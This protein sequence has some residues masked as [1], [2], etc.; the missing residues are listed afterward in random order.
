MDVYVVYTGNRFN[1]VL[2]FATYDDAFD[3]CKKATRWTDEEIE[4]AIKKPRPLHQ[5]HDGMWFVVE[6]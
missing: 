6:S 5:I 1:E 3:W 4:K 2:L